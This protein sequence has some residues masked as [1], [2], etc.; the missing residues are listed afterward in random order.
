L[1][2]PFFGWSDL[3]AYSHVFHLLR[4]VSTINISDAEFFLQKTG[5]VFS[6]VNDLNR[7]SMSRV[8]HDLLDILRV[9]APRKK[10]DEVPWPGKPSAVALYILF[11]DQKKGPLYNGDDEDK[12]KKN[13]H[14]SDDD[15]EP[16]VDNPAGEVDDE[17]EDGIGQP[18]R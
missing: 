15:N 4:D 7:E 14:N 16:E 6:K 5:T 10:A 12:K 8:I 17:D 11:G 1:L 9:S 3:V 13:N 2:F 18:A